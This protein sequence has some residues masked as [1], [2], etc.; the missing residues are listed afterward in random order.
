MNITLDE[1]RSKAPDGATHYHNISD[2]AVYLKGEIGYWYWWNPF[3]EEWMPD[4]T[5]DTYKIKPL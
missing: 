5:V 1:I 2:F 3:F 4:S